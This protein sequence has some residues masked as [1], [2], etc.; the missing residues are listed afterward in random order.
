MNVDHDGVEVVPQFIDVE[1]MTALQ[2]EMMNLEKTLSSKNKR[3]GIRNL[4]KKSPLVL[5]MSQ[6][7][8]VITLAKRYLSG[9]PQLVR[10][11]FFNKTPSSNWLVSWHQ[12]KTVAVSKR[13]DLPEWGPWSLKEGV[14]HV[15]APLAV[16][17]DMITL[18]IHL[19]DS[20]TFN[21]CLNV[22]PKSHAQGLMRQSEINNIISQDNIFTCQVKRGDI[23]VMRPHLLHSSRKAITPTQRRVIHLEYSSY[24]LPVGVDWA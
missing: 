19:D 12:D 15:Q 24:T 10:A 23:L 21:G 3:G 2:L 4:E 16:L 6:S 17:D 22:I 20:N 14:N 18:R 11:I 7:S 9:K 5:K 8:D 1:A 13:F